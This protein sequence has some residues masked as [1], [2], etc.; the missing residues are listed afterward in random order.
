MTT[1]TLIKYLEVELVNSNNELQ[2]IESKLE[3]PDYDGDWGSDN[4]TL[5][6]YMGKSEI[7]KTILEK[8][9]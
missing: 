7:L 6:Y 8:I 4:E 2:L 1:E 3:D 9:K 5:G